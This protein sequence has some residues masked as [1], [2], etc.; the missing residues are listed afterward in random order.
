M[1]NCE[2]LQNV[3]VNRVVHQIDTWYGKMWFVFCVYKRENIF[4]KKLLLD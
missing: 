1:E 3:M 2:K 4:N